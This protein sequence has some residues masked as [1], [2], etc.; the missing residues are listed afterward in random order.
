MKVFLFLTAF[1][2]CVFSHIL[3][4]Q[5]QMHL[6]KSGFHRELSTN[7]TFLQGPIGKCKIFLL[8]RIPSGAY[9]S[10]NEINDRI[11][12]LE[13][14]QIDSFQINTFGHEFDVEKPSFQSRGHKVAFIFEARYPSTLIHI[15]IH[16]RYQSPSK[17][18]SISYK[19][20]KISQPK[21]V[22]LLCENLSFFKTKW[23]SIPLVEVKIPVGNQPDS[24]IVTNVTLGICLLASLFLILVTLSK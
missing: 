12:H 5:V 23:K 2:V 15:P 1:V 24:F 9:L 22:T 3:D 8:Q 13:M 17:D 16:F 21:E 18:S 20:V 4:I 10:I 7:I 14:N 6:S 19:T 11:R